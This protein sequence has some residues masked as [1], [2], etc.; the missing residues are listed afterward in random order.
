VAIDASF[1]FHAPQE[2]QRFLGLLGLMA[3]I[4]LPQNFVAGSIDDRRFHR[5]RADVE[6]NQEFSAMIV[7]PLRRQRSDLQ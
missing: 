7:R 4:V 2:F 1:F 6:P 5:C 3:L